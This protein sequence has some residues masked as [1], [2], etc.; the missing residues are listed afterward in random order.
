M[1]KTTNLKRVASAVGLATL[2]GTAGCSCSDDDSGDSGAEAGA[3]G[4]AGSA[5]ATD[6]TGG[7]TSRAGSENAGGSTT[8]GGRNSGGEAGSGT[9]GSGEG[10]GAGGRAG[11]QAGAA[12]EGVEGGTAGSDQAGAG[13]VAPGAGG[14]LAAAGSAGDSNAPAM[15]GTE[16]LAALIGAICDWEF[17][18]CDRGEVDYRLGS[19]VTDAE[20]CRERFVAE[21][22]YNSTENPHQSGSAAPGTLLGT[23]AYTIDL[24]RVDVDVENVQ[25]C[26]EQQDAT[27]CNEPQPW[28]PEHCTGPIE[29]DANPCALANLF[30]PKLEAGDRCTLALAE[31]NTNDIECVPG[32]TCLAAGEGSP[33]S[34]PTCVTRGRGGAFC[35]SDSNCDFD[36]YC[37]PSGECVEKSDVGEDCSFEDPENP[38]PDE[39]E[40]A[41]KA[42]LTCSP[43]TLTCTEYCT[44]GYVCGAGNAGSDYDCPDGQSCAPITTGDDGSAFH[45]CR[46]L[47][48]NSQARCDD[49]MDCVATRNCSAAGG[50]CVPDEAAGDA[51]TATAQCEAGT[52]CDLGTGECTPYALPGDEC[53]REAPEACENPSNP[54]VC[55]FDAAGS[56]LTDDP[57]DI[58]TVCRTNL[59]GEGSECAVDLDCATGLCE[60]A[61]ED[62]AAPTC[63]T[64][65][66]AG[67]DCDD[68]V[69]SGTALRCSVGLTCDPE[70]DTCQA[71]A[72]PGE[73][74]ENE[75]GAADST[76]CLNSSCEEQWESL[77]CTDLAVPVESG[78]TGVT[79]D[80]T[81]EES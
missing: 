77:L 75:A 56:D 72:S 10:G 60:L 27:G 15:T 14:S 2:L 38:R 28:D 4:S 16:A 61:S 23:L 70:S 43:E 67:D 7:R 36:Y 12:G 40:L 44:T 69:A 47:G 50:V 58:V 68:D 29:L 19:F 64:G 78:G 51:C 24:D 54:M 80:G 3:S 20:T 66:G 55:V 39:V 13:G 21:L 32:T 1:M 73:S 26:I 18:C 46:D 76:L 6:G 30:V 52:Y 71:L 8:S 49:S 48:T 41:C 62:D 74:C 59:I 9:A 42:H 65:A 57:P 35:T 63:I 37:N 22:S 25:A 81:G 17:R 45:V 79:C 5:G 53:D 34:F 11:A 31:G 33:E